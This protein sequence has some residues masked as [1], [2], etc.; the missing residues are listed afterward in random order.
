ME[1]KNVEI[2]DVELEVIEE[3]EVTKVDKVKGFLKKHGNK[4]AIGAG[5]VA[6]VLLTRALFRSGSKEDDY[7]E[8]HEYEGVY[9]T[10]E[11]AQ[12]HVESETVL[13]D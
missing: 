5:A 9:M 8:L 4:I 3:T 6:G 1:D 12:A 11:E 13:E 2:I 7:I 10:D